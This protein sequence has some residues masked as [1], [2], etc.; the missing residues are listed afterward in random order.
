MTEGDE[1]PGPN[2]PAGGPII[3]ILGLDGA[4]KSTLVRESSIRF[5]A[6]ARKVAPFSEGLHRDAIAAGEALGA[7][8][9]DAIRGWALAS[10][11][12]IEASRPRDGLAVFDRYVESARMFLAVH[13]LPSLPD[14]VLALIPEPDLVVLLDIDIEFAMTR[15]TPPAAGTRSDAEFPYLRRCL[16][17]LRGTAATSDWLVLDARLP[18][19]ELLAQLDAPA[20]RLLSQEPLRSADSATTG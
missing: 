16:D 20:A 2:R 1:R 6:T 15:R 5:G 18:V 14:S 11:L 3:E 9:K 4:G 13:D 19:A 7:H 8:A 12:V 10:A 17:Y